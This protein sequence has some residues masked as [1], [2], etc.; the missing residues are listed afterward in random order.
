[1][2]TGSISGKANK[3]LLNLILHLLQQH[4]FIL[5]E[6]ID[7]RAVQTFHQLKTFQCVM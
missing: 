5:E 3:M 6:F 4:D 7:L 1:M 2:Q